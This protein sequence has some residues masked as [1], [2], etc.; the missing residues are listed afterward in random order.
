MTVILGFLMSLGKA[1]VYKHIP[2]YYPHHVGSVG[3]LVGVIGGLGG[4]FLPIAFGVLLD[5]TGVWTAPFMLLFVI[6]A[7]STVWMHVAIRRM[8]R[9]R[10]PGL[11]EEKFLSDVPQEPPPAHAQA[12]EGGAARCGLVVGGRAGRHPLPLRLLQLEQLLVQ[13]N[14]LRSRAAQGW[15]RRG[16]AALQRGA[17]RRRPSGPEARAARA[18]LSLGWLSLGCPWV[19]RAMARASAGG[20]APSTPRASVIARLG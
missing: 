16:T 18:G 15:A 12:R 11:A 19:A 20:G 17:P 3:G 4:F 8:E 10:H 5:L 2:V 7:V 14:L 9:A 6:V 13:R 1:A